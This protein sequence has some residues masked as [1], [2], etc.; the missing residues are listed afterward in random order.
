MLSVFSK[1][2]SSKNGVLSGKYDY[3]LCFWV[4]FQFL[5]LALSEANLFIICGRGEGA[6]VREEAGHLRGDHQEV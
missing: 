2:S 4:T 6:D 3:L 1:K 5:L